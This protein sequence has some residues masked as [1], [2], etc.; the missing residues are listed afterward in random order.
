MTLEAK[1]V[2]NEL[3]TAPATACKIE[4]NT[5][6]S[7]ARCQFILTQPVMTLQKLQE[8]FTQIAI[9]K[10]HASELKALHQQQRSDKR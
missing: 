8:L 10:H 3:T 4:E 6:L 2:L 5:H 1:D 7:L 9:D